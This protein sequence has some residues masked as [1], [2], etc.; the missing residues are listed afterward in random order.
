LPGILAAVGATAFTLSPGAFRAGDPAVGLLGLS[1]AFCAG[2][3]ERDLQRMLRNPGGPLRVAGGA[4]LLAAAALATVDGG[5]VLRWHFG[6]AAGATRI[7]LRSAGLLLGLALLGSLAGGL[8]LI[9]EIVSRG[10]RGSR[11]TGGRTLLGAA[12]LAL[13]AAGLVCVGVLSQD[14]EPSAEGQRSAALVVAVALLLLMAT[15]RLLDERPDAQEPDLHAG[16]AAF[17]SKVT[18]ALAMA[19]AG[20]VGL[21][22]WWRAGSYATPHAY[23][24]ASCAL[25]ALAA[26]PEGRWGPGRRA[27]LALALGWFL[28]NPA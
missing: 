14:A 9:G 23:Q 15:V 11:A 22:A 2:T 8:I 19:G 3:L 20:L 17:L 4:G 13:L 5:R 10:S 27:L 1:L 16:A 7:E 26:V 12:T 18:A 25:L 28:L 21:G 24:A 6:V